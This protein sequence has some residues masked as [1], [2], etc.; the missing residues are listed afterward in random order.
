MVGEKKVAVIMLPVL[1]KETREVIHPDHPDFSINALIVTSRVEESLSQVTKATIKP[2][3]IEGNRLSSFM[4]AYLTQQGKRDLFT[5]PEFFDA[6][7]RLSL[8]VKQRNITVM[9]A[10]LYAEQLIAAKK[11]ALQDVALQMPDNV[12]D[13]MLSYLNELNRAERED[14]LENRT[15]HHDAKLIG[16]EYLQSTYSPTSI[17]REDAITILGDDKRLTYLEQNLRLIQTKGPAQDRIC[18]ALDPLA[19]YL[20]GLHIVEH[21]G[22]DETAWQHFLEQVDE[23]LDASN[24]ISGF[25]LAVRDCCL[26]KEQDIRVPDFVISKLNSILDQVKAVPAPADASS[27]EAKVI[28]L[29]AH[30]LGK[31]A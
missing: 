7:S 15:V 19:E 27:A 4:E 12:P 26:A 17:T 6:C 30:A 10:K 24:T 14:R 1:S 28:G 3:R 16:W 23:R 2:L 11:E 5:D 21:Y 18:F 9:L 29:V 25:L 22:Q 13:L 8:M 20:A 31:S